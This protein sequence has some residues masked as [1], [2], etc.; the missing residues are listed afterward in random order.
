MNTNQS[1]DLINQDA[2][3]EMK[4][5][6]LKLEQVEL[7]NKTFENCQFEKSCFNEAKLIACQFI[8]CDFIS[9]NLSSV[10]LNH[11]S[12]SGAVFHES[13]LIG[14]NWTEARWP[15]IK[16][17]SPIQFHRS[18]IS[19]SS[20]YA[21]DL[22]EIIIEDCKAHDVDFREGDFSNGNFILTDF[23]RSQFMHTKLVSANFVEAINYYINPNENDIR[24]G[25]FSMP[26]VINLLQGFELEIQ[27]IDES[28]GV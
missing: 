25:K 17:T 23:E 18:N 3:Y 13:K 16:L 20:F 14:I 2:F 24:K 22:K 6:N 1:T 12:F 11:T 5:S 19:H 27:G 28:T 15:Y 9:C 10:R 26:D 21:L 7:K 4:F 8:D